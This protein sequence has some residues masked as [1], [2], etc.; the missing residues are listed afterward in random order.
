MKNLRKELDR[1]SDHV[2]YQSP[3]VKI[4]DRMIEKYLQDINYPELEPKCQANGKDDLIKVGCKYYCQECPLY[5]DNLND[6]AWCDECEKYIHEDD[7][8]WKNDL[9]LCPVCETNLEM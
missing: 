5:F 6:Y 4:T 7:Q 9:A 3:G 1:F 2:F 8:V